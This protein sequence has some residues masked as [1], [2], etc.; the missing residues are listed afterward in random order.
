MQKRYDSECSKEKYSPQFRYIKTI[1]M[2]L[3]WIG[4]GII[5][6]IIGPTIEDLRIYLNSDYN[7]LSFLISLKNVSHLVVIIFGGILFDKLSNYP[8]LIMCISTLLLI[9]RKF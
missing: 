3:T 6:E 5:G 7:N 8:D 1:F 2:I 4:F 9:I